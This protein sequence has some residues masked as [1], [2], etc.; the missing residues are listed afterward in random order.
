MRSPAR[1]CPRLAVLAGAPG[2]RAPRQGQPQ[3]RRRCP[4]SPIPPIPKLPAK[5]VF[6][7]AL[8]PTEVQARSIGFYSRGCLAGAKALP[9]DGETWQVMRLSRNRNLGQSGDDRLPRA[10]LE[11]GRREGDLA[12]HSRRRHFPAAR[13]PDADRPRLASGRPRRRRLADADARP[14]ADARGAGGDVRGQYGDRGRALGRPGALDAGVR[15]RSSRRPRKSPRSSASSS[16][17]RS[18]RRCARPHKGEPWMNKVRAYWGHN[19]HF[20]IRIECPAGETACE[21]QEPV[22]PGD[23]CDKSLA[24]WFTDEALHPRRRTKPKRRSRWRK[25]R[26]NADRWCWRSSGGLRLRR[27]SPARRDR[28]RDGRQARAAA[29]ET[30]NVRWMPTSQ[31]SSRSRIVGRPP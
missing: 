27:R 15:R 1:P 3:P 2:P 9:V 18:R 31:E 13:R 8:T 30:T 28:C 29:A 19:Y 7:R 24:W 6:G 23:G 22:P 4:R 25:C 11:K 20:H 12:R 10:L 26:P 16:T 17:P 14:H 5:Q 21:P